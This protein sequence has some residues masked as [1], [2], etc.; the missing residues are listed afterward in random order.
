MERRVKIVKV[1]KEVL[2]GIFKTTKEGV[3]YRIDGIPQD[4]EFID[5]HYEFSEDM[6]YFKYSHDSFDNVKYGEKIPI[7]DVKFTKYYV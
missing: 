7:H 4:A 6:F 1:A 5:A 2:G 3:A